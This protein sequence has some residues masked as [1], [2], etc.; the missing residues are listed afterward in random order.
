LKEQDVSVFVKWAAHCFSIR[1][2]SHCLSKPQYQT[3]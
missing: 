1:E 2:A 3:T